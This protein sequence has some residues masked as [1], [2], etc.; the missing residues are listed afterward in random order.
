[1]IYIHSEEDIIKEEEKDGQDFNLQLKKKNNLRDKKFKNK[2]LNENLN[3]S[4]KNDENS[5][6]EY[7]SET[8]PSRDEM[9]LEA[10]NSPICYT[11][12]F[13]INNFHIINYKIGKFDLFGKDYLLKY[14]NNNSSFRRTI[15]LPPHINV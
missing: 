3:E 13:N 11:R 14:G 9:N 4:N 15:N 8:I 1:L 7:S 6:H 2:F 10:N 5:Y 12:P